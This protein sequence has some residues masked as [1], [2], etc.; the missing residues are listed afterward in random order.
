MSVFQKNFSLLARKRKNGK[1]TYYV[2][3]K[4]PDGTYTTAKSTGCTTKKTAEEYCINL[5]IEK[6]DRH[7]FYDSNG[8]TLG[9]YSRGFYDY[10]DGRY[11]TF[12]EAGRAHATYK[13][14][15]FENHVLPYFRDYRLDDITKAE[16]RKFCLDLVKNKN[17]AKRTISRVLQTL[18][19]ILEYAEEDEII[20]NVPTFIK[21][22]ELTLC[23][24]KIKR[25][26][27]SD[28]EYRQLFN[29]ELWDNPLLYVVNI[30]AAVTGMRRAELAGLQI[31]DIMCVDGVY[32]VNVSR[33]FE[34]HF[35]ELKPPK[36]GKER[37]FEIT[38]ILARLLFSIIEQN[39]Y[40]QPNS[41]LF[42]SQ[43]SG[44]YPLDS[45]LYYKSLITAI[46]KIGITNAERKT[47]G[48]V[49]HSHRKYAFTKYIENGVPEIIAKKAL[50][51]SI[52]GMSGVYFRGKNTSFLIPAQEEFFKNIGILS[53]DTTRTP[54]LQTA[55]K[56]IEYTGV[57]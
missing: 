28:A 55:G 32:T 9:D 18:R 40:K 29:A 26:T 21:P 34:Y 20:R 30:T 3:W 43:H 6:G 38:P 33:A 13:K 1:T 17:L 7:Y 49:F 15:E 45:K 16:I 56:E 11:F 5:Q 4:Q 8:V 54:Y 35:R 48:I 51:H 22:Q 23:K 47:R 50:G 36:N 39:P 52:R 44:E 10:P 46:E 2:R 31:Q 57:K 12:S 24:P 42:Y 37:S 25:D 41:F 19:P 14:T 27:L 53:H